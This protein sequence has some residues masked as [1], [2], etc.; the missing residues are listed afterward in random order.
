MC[1]ASLNSGVSEIYSLRIRPINPT[2][3]PK[4]K[5]QR[6]AQSG[7]EGSVNSREAKVEKE[8][9]SITLP[10]NK[11]TLRISIKLVPF[12]VSMQYLNHCCVQVSLRIKKW[13]SQKL[14]SVQPILKYH[15]L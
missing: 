7:I 11:E 14:P 13:F 4:R 1:T 5:A 10:L 8:L 6:H 9:F 12:V 3:E 15:I 2:K